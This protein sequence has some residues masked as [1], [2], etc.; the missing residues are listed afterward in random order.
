MLRA[1]LETILTDG[2]VDTTIVDELEVYIG[3]FF[4]RRA[5]DELDKR[6]KTELIQV[7]VDVKKRLS[8]P[9]VA[10]LPV[11]GIGTD[12]LKIEGDRS[13]VCDYYLKEGVP[14]YLTLERAAKALANLAGYYER[15]NAISS[16]N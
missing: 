16:A 10:V 5:E 14:V 6:K 1:V 2:N 9:V 12:S 7:P 3:A 11:E 13:N 15:R 4:T 8:K